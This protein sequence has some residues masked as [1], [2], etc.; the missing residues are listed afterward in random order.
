M[1]EEKDQ[2]E[3]LFGVRLELFTGWRSGCSSDGSWANMK[4]QQ[5][6]WTGVALKEKWV[7]LGS[8]VCQ[9]GLEGG[10]CVGESAAWSLGCTVLPVGWTVLRS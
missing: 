2:R 4:T 7:V 3:T 10:S 5:T 1:G 8:G 9:G 6:S